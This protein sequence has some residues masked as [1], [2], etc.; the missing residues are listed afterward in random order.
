MSDGQKT[1]VLVP[2]PEVTPKAKRRGFSPSY[3]KKILA[4]VD[5][6][7]GT[8]SIGFVSEI[9]SDR[10][11]GSAPWPNNNNLR[12]LPS[13]AEWKKEAVSDWVKT[14]IPVLLDV[15]NGYDGRILFKDKPNA[16]FGDNRDATD[17]RWRNWVSEL[18]GSGIKGIVFDSWNGYTEGFAAVPSWEHQATV[19]RWVADLLQ[20][21][22]RTCNHVHYAEGVRTFRVYGAICD[23][24]VRMG[25]NRSFAAPASNEQPTQGGRGRVSYFAEGKAIYWSGP[26][27]A[28][29]VH[30]IIEQTYRA[31]GED[32]SCLRLPISDEEGGSIVGVRARISRFEGGTIEWRPGDRTGRITCQ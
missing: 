5:A 6:A 15:T 10:L 14:G 32:R 31:A 9:F 11:D 13:L 29:E 8:G 1:V 2:D 26:T 7:V 30:G 27:G 3:K 12:N 4:E 22:P 24:W 25:G 18:K 23:A 28:H 17:D 21:D 20:P 19:A 16:I